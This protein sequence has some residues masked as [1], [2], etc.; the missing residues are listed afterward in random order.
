MAFATI[1]RPLNIFYPK[2]QKFVFPDF[3]LNLVSFSF[4][5]QRLFEQRFQQHQR[6]IDEQLRE[7]RNTIARIENYVNER[8]QRREIERL[9]FQA[10]QRQVADRIQTMN[11]ERINRGLDIHHGA[12][13]RLRL[14]TINQPRH[15][16]TD[17]IL[18]IPLD[19]CT[20]G[21]VH[22][23]LDLCAHGIVNIPLGL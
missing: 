20:I 18:N 22:I 3:L 7:T 15:H 11:R 17:G 13:N 19:L 12:E 1:L 9:N 4:E 16:Q 21:I 10:D 2:L 8:N 14:P 23:L 6:E 5:N